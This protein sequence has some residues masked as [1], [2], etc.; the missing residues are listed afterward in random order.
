MPAVARIILA[1]ADNVSTAR[2]GAFCRVAKREAGADEPRRPLPPLVTR[3]A[4]TTQIRLAARALFELEPTRQRGFMLR[5]VLLEA[6]Q[7]GADVIGPGLVEL[8][9]L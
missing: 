4:A 9:G 3:I 2:G 8:A 5:G 7:H 1:A 6:G